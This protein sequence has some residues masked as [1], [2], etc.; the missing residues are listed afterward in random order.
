MIESGGLRIEGSAPLESTGARPRASDPAR[1][2]LVAFA[3]FGG[4]ATVTGVGIFCYPSTLG[5]ARR[6]L[7]FLHDLSGDLGIVIGLAYLAAHLRRVFPMKRRAMS[8]WT[9]YFSVAAFL[10]AAVTGVYGEVA[11]MPSGSP[12]SRAHLFSSLALVGL[13]CFHGAW[14]LR[15]KPR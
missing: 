5:G 4:L 10:I 12:L 7:V 9:G 11:G 1:A 6:V 13:A 2:R 8:R 3:V 14:G 15:P